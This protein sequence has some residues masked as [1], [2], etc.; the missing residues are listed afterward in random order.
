MY[1]HKKSH[2]RIDISMLLLNKGDSIISWYMII[3][4]EIRCFGTSLESEV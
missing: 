2:L 1:K 3:I 4:L